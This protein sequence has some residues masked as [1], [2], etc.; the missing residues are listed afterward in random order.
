MNGALK[1]LR[2]LQEKAC[3]LEWRLGVNERGMG[4]KSYAV[5]V[6]MVNAPDTYIVVEAPCYEIADEIIKSH[7]KSIG[8]ECGGRCQVTLH[9][10]GTYQVG[11]GELSDNGDWEH[12]CARCARALEPFLNH[13]FPQG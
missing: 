10:N 6:V 7:N 12:S 3:S 11:H 4:R 2:F 8:I 1:R 5:V 9:T 13:Y